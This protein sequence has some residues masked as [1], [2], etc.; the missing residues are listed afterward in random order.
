MFVFN[1]S[2]NIIQ[3]LDIEK[4]FMNYFAKKEC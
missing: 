4:L 3:K 2:V 1:Y